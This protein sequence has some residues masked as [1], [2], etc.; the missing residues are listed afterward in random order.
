[1][2]TTDH[3][4]VLAVVV[5]DD[6]GFNLFSSM[7]RYSQSFDWQNIYKIRLRFALSFHGDHAEK[8]HS[9]IVKTVV[10]VGHAQFYDED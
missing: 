1:M 9:E 4:D 5:H 7:F 2:L 3:V 8:L 6:T 10:I